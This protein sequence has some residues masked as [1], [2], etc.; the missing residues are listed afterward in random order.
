MGFALIGLATA[1][2]MPGSLNPSEVKDAIVR[3]Y[4]PEEIKYLSVV[5]DHETT[6]ADTV[7]RNW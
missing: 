1:P 7:Y 4:P 3:V 5:I 2:P 6:G